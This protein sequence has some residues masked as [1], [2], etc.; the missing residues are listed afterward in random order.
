MVDV[1]LLRHRALAVILTNAAAGAAS[2]ADVAGAFDVAFW[3]AVG[4]TVLAVPL[5]L[6]LPARPAR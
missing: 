4:L 3:W 1:R 5:S 6:A 2:R